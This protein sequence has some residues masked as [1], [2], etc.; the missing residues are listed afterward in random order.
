MATTIRVWDGWRAIHNGTDV[1]QFVW[2]E[3]DGEPL[4]T[5]RCVSDGKETERSF[6][7]LSDGRIIV[8][9]HR[10]G[11]WGA[12]DYDIG[13]VE[14]YNTLDRAAFYYRADLVRIGAYGAPTYKLDD[15]LRRAEEE[16]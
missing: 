4:G 10:Y 7:R 2:L 14:V 8:A 13:V 15:W 6:Y 12:G 11:D 3:F 5:L 16:E 9:E 1:S